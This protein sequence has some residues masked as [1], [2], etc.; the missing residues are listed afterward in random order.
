MVGIADQRL[1]EEARQRGLLSARDLALVRE[2]E[3][4]FANQ[5][6]PE[7]G[8]FLRA[9]M[10]GPAGPIGFNP[11]ELAGKFGT[12]DE[13]SFRRKALAAV[14]GPRNTL[15]KFNKLREVDPA[16]T[17]SGGVNG[18]P[19][20]VTFQGQ[21]F[22]LN[23]P[24]LSGQD[25]SDFAQDALF[26][27]PLALALGPLGGK[28]A[29]TAGRVLGTGLGA[30]T[31]SAAR[32]VAAE[33]PIDML[34][35]GLAA[36]TGVAFEAIGPFLV[37]R[38]AT[39]IRSRKLFQNGEFTK[40]GR[41]ALE[42][43]GLDPDS[44]SPD[45]VRQIQ[46]G[47]SPEQARLLADAESLPQPVRLSQGDVTRDVTQQALE[48]AA[49]RG[50]L[51]ERANDAA[52]AFRAQ[53]A[54][55]L[56]QNLDILQER[57]GPGGRIE[58]RGDAFAATQQALASE[59]VALKGQIKQGF[60][61]AKQKNAS[62]LSENVQGLAQHMRNSI[63]HDFSPDDAGSVN[64]IIT[65]LAEFQQRFGRGGANVTGVNIK[66]LEGTR[67]KLVNAQKAGGPQGAAATKAK[68]AFDE[69]LDGLIDEGLVQG[70]ADVVRALKDARLARTQ[71]RQKFE[72]DNIVK[73]IIET[74]EDASGIR[75]LKLQPNEA[76]NLIFTSSQLGGKTGAV[77]ALRNIRK[78]VGEDSVAWMSL[79]EEAFLRL[80]QTA[81]D[82]RRVSG[83]KFATAVDRALENQG[84]L[85]DTLFTG[86][87]QAE[88]QRFKRVA[89]AATTRETGAQ[90]FSNTTIVDR[91]LDSFGFLG[92]TARSATKQ[93]IGSIESSAG[94]QTRRGFRQPLP[95]RDVLPQGS[96]AAAGL[97]VTQPSRKARRD[98]RARAK[99]EALLR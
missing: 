81:R 36:G 66:A 99:I 64:G 29:G 96:A 25:V 34:N 28:V 45:L 67:R 43:I 62:V 7:L 78:V 54:D 91:I 89:L 90:N 22:A 58:R 72:T 50:G 41:E 97:L 15:D 40:K 92:S 80:M 8:S 42:R 85:F 9:Q 6:L 86:A 87:E 75:Q 84:E 5:D 24:G 57:V 63:A 55:E 11:A 33:V 59:A 30:G 93:L 65:E 12:P 27:L 14:E 13:V 94:R 71:F 74:T 32:D 48:D 17:L 88:I 26:E 1:L 37:N 60:E 61:L 31:G 52:V 98:A 10:P 16:A 19:T 2:N 47:A 3:V 70:D 4:R 38:I 46:Q 35:A 79:K 51:G 39:F 23:R 18:D 76:L 20:A 21:R 49:A 83:Q 95:Q 68:R 73:R 77:N 53:Q 82:G 44:V 56:G 69:Y